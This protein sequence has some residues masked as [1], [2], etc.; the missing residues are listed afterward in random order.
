METAYNVNPF[1]VYKRIEFVLIGLNEERRT[2]DI[3]GIDPKVAREL[4][5]SSIQK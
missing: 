3:Y 5:M 1:A 2:A 4:G